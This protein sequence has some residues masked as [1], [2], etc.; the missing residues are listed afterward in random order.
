[1]DGWMD[2]PSPGI[3][4]VVVRDLQNGEHA[5]RNAERRE[6]VVHRPDFLRRRNLLDQ[7]RFLHG[8]DVPICKCQ[9]RNNIYT[10]SKGN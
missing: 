4:R 6:F 7:R 5:R 9:A 10:F 2:T 1:M 3:A 8:L